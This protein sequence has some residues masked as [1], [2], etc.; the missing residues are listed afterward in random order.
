MKA[1]DKEHHAIVKAIRDGD[2]AAAAR[3]MHQHI[4]LGGDAMVQLVLA[5]QTTAEVAPANP[6]PPPAAK[7][8]KTPK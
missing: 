3:A 1:S 6:M 5:A 7:K 8:R 4:D 2:A